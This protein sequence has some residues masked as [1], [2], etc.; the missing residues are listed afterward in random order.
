MYSNALL[1]CFN[2]RHP[3]IERRKSTAA[4]TQSS[5]GKVGTTSRTQMSE[6]VTSQLGETGTVV[7]TAAT[8]LAFS[9]TKSVAGDDGGMDVPD[10]PRQREYGA[11]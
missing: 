6:A 1:S 5:T 7:S 9:K 10:L 2:S 8:E 11:K 4:L 3:F